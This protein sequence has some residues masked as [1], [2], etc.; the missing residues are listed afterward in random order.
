[1]RLRDFVDSSPRDLRFAVRGLSRRPTFTL[2]VVL[3]L[4]LGIGATTAVGTDLPS[5]ITFALRSERTGTESMLADIRRAVA[6]MA[7]DFPLAA[8]GTLERVYRDHASMA[9]SSFSL[10]LLGIAGATALLLS[11]VGIYSPLALCRHAAPARGWNPGRA[12]RRAASRENDVRL[13]RAH[14]LGRR[15][16]RRGRSGSRLDA[17]DV[18]AVVRRHA[19]RRCHF[20]ARESRTGVIIKADKL[21]DIPTLDLQPWRLGLEANLLKLVRYTWPLFPPGTNEAF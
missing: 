4:A 18:V 13:S 19:A 17:I 3:T 16:R 9:H 15:N 2:A 7:P 6:E 12:R 20:R 10:A 1:M 14:S 11:I 21:T 8:V 5:S